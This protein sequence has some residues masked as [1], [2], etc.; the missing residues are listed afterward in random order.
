MEM[1]LFIFILLT[2]QI[3][4]RISPV[5][6]NPFYRMSLVKN[7]VRVSRNFYGRKCF[8]IQF[9]VDLRILNVDFEPNLKISSNP[10]KSVYRIQIEGRRRK[11]LPKFLDCR[12]CSRNFDPLKMTRSQDINIV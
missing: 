9:L 8:E 2:D 6:P 1:V 7:L 3:G 4:Q 10:I 5:I 11:S 12:M